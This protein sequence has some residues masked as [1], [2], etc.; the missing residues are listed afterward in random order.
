MRRARLVAAAAV[1]TAAVLS[2][3][4]ALTA[5]AQSADAAAPA[6]P[7]GAAAATQS[8]YWRWSDGSEERHRTFRRSEYRV[9]ERLPRL[10]VSAYPSRPSRPVRLEFRRG[11]RWQLEDAGSLSATGS[12]AL[13]LTPYC[14]DGRWCD[15]TLDYRAVVAGQTASLRVTYV[16]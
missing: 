4:A 14:D 15:A 9:P 2:G 7:A 1:V 13:S 16:R 6:A 3:L 8:Y 10:I 5:T 11:G 12:V